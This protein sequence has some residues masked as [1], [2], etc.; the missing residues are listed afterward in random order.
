[1]R[2]WPSECATTH[3]WS[4]RYNSKSW[5]NWTSSLENV[6]TQWWWVAFHGMEVI[7]FFFI[8][9]S[10]VDP[11]GVIYSYVY[12]IYLFSI[13]FLILL[14]CQSSSRL[15]SCYYT[16]LHCHPFSQTINCDD[17]DL[18]FFNCKP[19]FVFLH[20]ENE[21]NQITHT[22]THFF[23]LHFVACPN[24]VISSLENCYLFRPLL[25]I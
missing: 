21:L 14:S 2:V 10:K 23:V 24:H 15:V 13:V 3:S 18:P 6:F 4:F 9:C 17:F 20:F 25:Y 7:T 5:R 22:H 16:V 19:F 12:R 1:M 11:I 8:L